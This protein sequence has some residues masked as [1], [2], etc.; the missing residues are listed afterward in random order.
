M[1]SKKP[2]EN[3][4]ISFLFENSIFL[5]A[6][7]VL[8][9][10]WANL[11]A[12]FETSTYH[13]FVEFS[14]TGGDGHGNE[15]AH[16]D[17]AAADAGHADAGHTD[18]HVD[19]AHTD[20]A[21][22]SD[23]H[24][25]DVASDTHSAGNSHSSDGHTE[26][27]G[28]H[29]WTLHFF[30]NDVLMALF[31]A[32]AVKEVWESM[33]PGGSLANPKR[34]ATPLLATLGGIIGPAGLYLVC[35]WFMGCFDT[36]ANGWAIPCATDIAFS[37]LVARIIFGK[38]H[39]AIAFLLLLAIADDAAGLVILAVFYPSAELSPMWLSLTGVAIG[40][41]L[42]L[43][44]AGVRNFWWYL[45]VPGVLSWISFY[46]AGIHPALG[47]AP[48][49]PTLPHAHGDLGIFAEGEKHRH[50]TLNNFEHW[51]KNPVELILGLFALVNA[52][53]VFSSVGAGTFL[54]LVGLI[55]GKPLG[56]AL[57]AWLAVKAFR[58][59]MPAGMD[60]REIVVIGCIASVGFT[61]ALFVSTA[62]FPNPGPIQSSVKMG[63][64]ASF[65]APVVAFIVARMLGVRP[66][67]HLAMDQSATAAIGTENAGFESPGE[68]DSKPQDREEEPVGAT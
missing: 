57:F 22:A 68:F 43:R 6:G 21:H 24:A 58:L 41:G 31:F 10:T 46:K 2:R 20:D 30:V 51:W 42:M 23:A 12:Y 26:A 65:F 13:D 27:A 49:I 64:L 56:I 29:S 48:I 17:H 5:V 16:T 35:A 3:R 32:L 4:V 38:G 18:A 60:M 15:V 67:A 63:A 19:D 37:Y 1:T 61:V 47:L 28:H 55:L 44:K 33:L 8:A 62:A 45:L 52:G 66:G 50:D 40:L 59:Q 9:L 11:D 53:V 14:L 25:T 54:V 36:L 7:S 39:P 34:A